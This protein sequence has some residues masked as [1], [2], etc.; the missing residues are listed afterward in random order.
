[1]RVEAEAACDPLPVGGA[2][3]GKAPAVRRQLQDP[4]GQRLGARGRNDTPALR[5][6]PFPVAAD[7]AG[8][9]REPARHR[10]DEGVREALLAGGEDEEVGCLEEGSRVELLAREL[11]LVADAEPR[12]LG[13]EGRPVGSVA[14]QDEPRL[15]PRGAELGQGA[16][17]VLLALAGRE[18]ADVQQPERALATTRR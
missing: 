14:D 1:R 16:E 3:G 5:S 7:V 15:D 8:D 17:A 11:N 6:D 9:D 2:D 12:R 13:F 10:L 4:G 18:R